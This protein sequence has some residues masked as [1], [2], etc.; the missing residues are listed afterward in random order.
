MREALHGFD[1]KRGLAVLEDQGAL[2]PGGS[3][4]RSKAVRLGGRPVKVYVLDPVR[5][6]GDS[7]VVG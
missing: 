1:F 5:L 6:G 7:Y 2:L 4:E 3:G